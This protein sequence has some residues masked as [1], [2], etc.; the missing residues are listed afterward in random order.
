MQD[1]PSEE[2]IADAIDLIRL[3]EDQFV[4]WDYLPDDVTG[5]REIPTP[6]T[7]EQYF[8]YEPVD[9]SSANMA[10]AYLSLYAVT[11]D[12]LAL[13]KA[14]ALMDH[15]TILQNQITGM[16]ISID[17]PVEYFWINCNY[18]SL[19][20]LMRLAEVTGE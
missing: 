11:G 10:D 16:I 18:G 9:A 13:E 3:S 14:R 20:T 17:E 15:L 1:N 19:T 2:D 12:R 8:C 4:H 5:V 7:F 6:S